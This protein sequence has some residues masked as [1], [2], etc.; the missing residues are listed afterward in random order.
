MAANRDTMEA[1]LGMVIFTFMM[2]HTE[3]DWDDEEVR[4]YTGL[5]P[6]EFQIGLDYCKRNRLVARTAP[7]GTPP[8]PNHIVH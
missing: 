7:E 5:T 3:S 2:N 8:P 6:A 1:H 4:R